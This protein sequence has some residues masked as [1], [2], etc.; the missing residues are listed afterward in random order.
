MVGRAFVE[1]VKF[2]AVG[3]AFIEAST[4]TLVE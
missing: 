4:F 1:A 2:A 3:R